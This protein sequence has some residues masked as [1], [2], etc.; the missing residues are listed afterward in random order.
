MLYTVHISLWISPSKLLQASLTPPLFNYYKV[1]VKLN[2]A[3]SIQSESLLSCKLHVT[4][5]AFATLFCGVHLMNASKE[6]IEISGIL[7][8]DLAY[9][10]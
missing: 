2:L 9:L 4:L 10:A 8:K 5:I 3:I 6:S 7:S 1:I